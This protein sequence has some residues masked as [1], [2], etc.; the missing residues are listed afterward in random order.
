[1][2]NKISGRS[3]P[4]IFVHKSTQMN[5]L[6][7]TTDFSANSASAIKFAMQVAK[8]AGHRLIFYHVIEVM[9]PTS[10][11]RDKYAKFEA[12]KKAEFNEKLRKFVL[13]AGKGLYKDESLFTYTSEIGMEVA[14][15]VIRAA[16]KNKVSFICTSTKGAGNVKRLF[17][18]NST[19]LIM[20]SPVPLAIV[21]H[22]YKP[23]KITKLFYSS[24]LAA[25]KAEMKVV[26]DLAAKLKSEVTVYHYDY[27]LQAGA[28][29]KQLEK[30]VTPFAVKGV[31]FNF[32]R[33]EI[34][35][36]LSDHLNRDIKKE[37]PSAVIL[38]TKQNRNW[39]DRLFSPSAT[40]SLSFSAA[41]PIIVF[42]KSV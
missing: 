38:F 35:I 1:M 18:T 41:V 6:L 36:S 21:P 7:V 19:S 8:Q 5:S 15:L 17:G 4:P 31:R 33:Q 28:S 42:R 13:S 14:D 40:A 34:D 20:H 37:Q 26:N 27:M 25:L 10:W 30:K 12:S 32:K 23:E 39:F 9:Q 2:S 24:D 11:S 3:F 16:R 22:K 29:A